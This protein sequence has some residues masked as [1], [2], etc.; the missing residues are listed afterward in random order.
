[1]APSQAAQREQQ[2]A[3]LA[4]RCLL[5]LLQRMPQAKPTGQGQ[6]RLFL[7]ADAIVKNSNFSP[8]L[9]LGPRS[10]KQFQDLL[11]HSD[12]DLSPEFAQAY[13]RGGLFLLLLS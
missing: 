2:K 7:K 12:P 6:N 11:P 3:A 1:M 8:G 9:R 5:S 4:R 13:L 10:K